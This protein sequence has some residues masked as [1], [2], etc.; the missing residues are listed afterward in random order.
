S[1]GFAQTNTAVNFGIVVITFSVVNN[2]VFSLIALAVTWL[3]PPPG[4]LPA[5]VALAYFFRQEDEEEE[6]E[7][8]ELGG[9][10][11][12]GGEGGI[13]DDEVV[14][15]DYVHLIMKKFV[16]KYGV[17]GTGGNAVALGHHIWLARRNNVTPVWVEP[18]GQDA[19]VVLSERRRVVDTNARTVGDV[20]FLRWNAVVCFHHEVLGARFW[21]Q[22]VASF[23]R[24]TEA[25]EHTHP[26]R[27]YDRIPKAINH[28][29]SL[30]RK[31]LAKLEK[32]WREKTITILRR[33]HSRISRGAKL[34]DADTSKEEYKTFLYGLASPM[35]LP[36]TKLGHTNIL[37]SRGDK[38]FIVAMVGE[39]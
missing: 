4:L 38:S 32:R 27:V 3:L 14:M 26:Q 29:I 39:A 13:G 6:E 28:Y 36:S 37:F 7:E 19:S 22:R 8:E 23:W 34:E 11:R 31:H 5:I 20:C 24:K 16:I 15:V 10:R 21:I 17:L 35:C 12:G 9:Q 2:I 1:R 25:L 33:R 18:H 30:G